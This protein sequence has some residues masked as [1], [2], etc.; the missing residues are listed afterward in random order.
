MKKEY[1][2]E[3]DY[4]VY[5]QSKIKALKKEK[6]RIEWIAL[7]EKIKAAWFEALED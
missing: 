4:D 2:P 5:R 1:D 7:K 3:L 6:R